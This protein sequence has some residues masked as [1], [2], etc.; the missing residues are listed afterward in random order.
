MFR[1]GR[2]RKK[3]VI[4]L[5]KNTFRNSRL[6]HELKRVLSE[7]L[8]M[9]SSTDYDTVDAKKILV[10]DVVVSPDLRYAKVFISHIG[11]DADNDEYID[12]LKNHHGQLRHHVAQKIPLRYVPE[13]VFFVDDSEEYAQHIDSLLK[14]ANKRISTEQ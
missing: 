4:M 8:L 2:S 7:F 12:F 5:K 13:L 11:N 3:I 9:D 14:I 1:I 10:T 6:A